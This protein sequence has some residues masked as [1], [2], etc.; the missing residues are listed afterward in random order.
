MRNKRHRERKQKRKRI[1]EWHHPSLN[2]RQGLRRSNMHLVF[3]TAD[4]RVKENR[5]GKLAPGQS[6]SHHHR[7][8]LKSMTYVRNHEL[9]LIANR[10]TRPKIKAG[11]RE[12]GQVESGREDG[13]AAQRGSD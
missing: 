1:P 5:H 8:N 10:L 3:Q 11:W 12:H 6:A 9:T 4:P 13:E 2:L 7:C